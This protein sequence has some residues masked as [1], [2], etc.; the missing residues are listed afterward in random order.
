MS[1]NVNDSTKT[2]SN[3]TNDATKTMNDNV[4]DSTKNAHELGRLIKNTLCHVNLIQYN[5]NGL[6][7]EKSSDKQSKFFAK[8]LETYKIPVSLRVSR[9]QDIFGACGQLAGKE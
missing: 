8:I 9:G 5:D 1:N 6:G 7:F 3:D 2:I 4:N